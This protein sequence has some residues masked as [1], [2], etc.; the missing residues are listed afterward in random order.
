MPI[1][2]SRADPS[3]AADVSSDP[4]VNAAPTPSREEKRLS[5][6]PVVEKVRKFAVGLKANARWMKTIPAWRQVSRATL[7]TDAL[8]PPTLHGTQAFEMFAAAP[9]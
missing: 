1:T 3:A 4:A 7:R 9:G 2:S 8:Q 6:P 5:S